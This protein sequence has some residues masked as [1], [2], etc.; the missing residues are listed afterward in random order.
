V[1]AH[2]LPKKN[3]PLLINQPTVRNHLTNILQE[4]MQVR[5]SKVEEDAG[6]GGGAMVAA[7]HDES[8]PL[9]LGLR[10]ARRRE[11]RRQQ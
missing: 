4:P 3:P 10:I 2:I 11:L 9:P 6:G 1:A 5:V 8:M 7:N